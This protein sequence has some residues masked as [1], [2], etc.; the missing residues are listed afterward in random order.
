MTNLG[1][2]AFLTGIAALGA[3]RAMG[4]E[5]VTSPRPLPRPEGFW[6]RAIPTP[7]AL[8]ARA[9]LSGEVCF[10]LRQVSDGTPL[11]VRSP[12]R[13]MPPASVAKVLTGYYALKTLG[14]GF[15]FATEILAT[16]S[17]GADGTV[18]GDLILRGSG[19]PTLD[20]DALGDM[21][22]A[23]AARGVRGLTGRFFVDASAL[24]FTHEIDR[25]QTDY[26]GYNPAISGLN[27]NYNRV[28][29]E[30]KKQAEGYAITMDARAERFVPAVK[31]ATMRIAD[32]DRPVF[33]WSA[34]DDGRDAWSVSRRALGNGGARWLPVRKPGLYAGEVFATLAAAHGIRLGAPEPAPAGMTGT[35]LASHSSRPLRILVR[36]MLK[37]STNLTAEVLGLTASRARGVSDL[38]LRGSAASMSDWARARLGLRHVALVDHSG[39]GDA[40]RVSSHDL[41]TTLTTP[42]VYAALGPLLKPITLRGPDGKPDVDHPIKVFAKTGTLDFV[43]GLAGYMSAPDGQEMAFAIFAA[44]AEARSASEGQEVPQ[45][46][47]GWNK[48][49]KTLQQA[50][51]ERWGRLYG[52]A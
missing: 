9:K 12:L 35:R 40:S 25:R 49:A 43:S 10:A 33:A 23:L 48:S 52:A 16:G 18:Q 8:I 36:D 28:H 6:R 42:D 13:A 44:D 5:V 1:R 51:I 7:D 27:L 31:R 15:A 30:W 47:K 41:M 24:P 14:P 37:Y 45:G 50:L 21:A 4:A 39:L 20:T 19:D 2:R 26:A 38:S 34:H 32:R 46:A 29:F 3:G 11:E 22:A 17:I